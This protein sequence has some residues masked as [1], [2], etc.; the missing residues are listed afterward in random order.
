MFVARDFANFKADFAAG[1]KN[2]LTPDGLGAFIL[3]LA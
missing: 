3:V 2:M 1:L